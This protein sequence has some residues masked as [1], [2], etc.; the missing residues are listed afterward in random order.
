MHVEHLM[1]G[2]PVT[3]GLKETFG[4]A[5]RL[6]IEHRVRSLP[7]VD[8]HWIYKGMFDLY[9]VWAQMLPRAA[10]LDKESLEDLSYVSSSIESLR[11]KLADADTRSIREFLDTEEAPAIHPDT[12]VIEAVRLL[13]HHGGNLAVVDRKTHRLVGLVSAWEILKHLG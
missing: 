2:Q 6:L 8:E 11:E 5:L 4:S 3:I 7:V 12:P 10:M 13:Y 1:N 9:D